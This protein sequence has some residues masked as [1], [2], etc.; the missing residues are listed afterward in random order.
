MSDPLSV[1]GSAIGI[2]SLGITVAQGLFDYYA[3][4]QGQKSDVAH[5]AKKLARLL[6]MLESLRHQLERRQ[7]RAD[8]LALLTNMKSSM[9]DCKE[10]VRELEEVSSKFNQV[11]HQGTMAEFHATGPR[12]AYP[13][14][15][16]TL[17]KLDEDVVDFVSCLSLVIQM[18]QQSDSC[19]VQDGIED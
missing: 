18:L 12:V 4:F 19:N 6:E 13:F 8:D 7:F 11:R 5:T 1:A 9:G 2:I 14:R 16:S 3:A 17:Q 15:Q 10:L